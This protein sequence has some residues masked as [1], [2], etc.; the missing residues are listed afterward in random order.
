MNQQVESS[1]LLKVLHKRKLPEFQNLPEVCRF[2]TKFVKKQYNLRYDGDINHG[3]CFIWAY[4]VWALN[5]EEVKFATTDGHVLV[6]H[7][8][9]YFDSSNPHGYE[10]LED[11]E[12]DPDEAEIVDV[13]GM[14]WYWSRCGVAKKQFRSLLRRTCLRIYNK[15]RTGGFN[16]GDDFYLTMLCVEDIP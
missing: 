15:V 11:A 7:D 16:D 14:A 9:L 6:H 2:V 3:Y 5:K 10:C 8:D 12:L 13:R 1:K 4:L